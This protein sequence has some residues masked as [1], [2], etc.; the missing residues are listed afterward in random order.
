M[1][2]ASKV[3]NILGPGGKIAA[4]LSAYEHRPQQLEMAE[5]VAAALAGNA[6]RE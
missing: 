5:K 1:S 4:R 3:A 2:P 6:P